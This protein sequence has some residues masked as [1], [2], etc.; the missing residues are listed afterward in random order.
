[1]DMNRRGGQRKYILIEMGDWTESV[2]LPRVKKV[3]YCADWSDGK[4]AGGAGVS[5]VMKY[6]LIEQYED[7]LG[8]IEVRSGKGTQMAMEMFG[9]EYLLRYMLD[10]ETQ[11][12]TSLLNLDMFK[13]PFAYRLKAQVGD[14][15]Q[16]CAVDLIETFNYLMGLDVRKLRQLENDGRRYRV[17]LGEK[18]GKRIAVVWRSVKDIENDKAALMLDKAFVE[19]TILPALLG[20][21]VK[22]DRVFV[23]GASFVENAEAIESEFKRLMFAPIG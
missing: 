15:V 12:S 17:V 23:N 3:A 22:P 10:S 20:N 16:E 14:E 2:I 18:N 21:G 8:N 9:D 6:A 1:M 5:H 19:G 7:T 4:P 13:D 11:G